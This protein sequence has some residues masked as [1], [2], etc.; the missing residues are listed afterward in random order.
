MPGG[1]GGKKRV[2]D[3]AQSLGGD[4]T[5][6]IMKFQRDIWPRSHRGHGIVPILVVIWFQMLNICHNGN[7]SRLIADGFSG[8]NNQ[9]HNDL[10]HLAESASMREGEELSR[11]AEVNMFRDGG[12]EE[13]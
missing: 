9:I 7:R 6:V 3:S 10:L 1:F 8:I 4:A 5:A 12:G 13:M 11:R 2:K